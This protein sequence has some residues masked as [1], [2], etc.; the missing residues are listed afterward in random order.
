MTQL[1]L[2]V[3]GE[4]LVLP[5]CKGFEVKKEPG[6]I[7]VEMITRRTVLEQRGDIW[8]VSYQYGFFDDETKSRVL[9]ACEKGREKPIYCGFLPPNSAGALLY[10][11]F[12]V[13]SL[14][15]PKFMWSRSVKTE[16]GTYYPTPLWADFSIELREVRPSA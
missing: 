7:S 15:Y 12:Y 2:D 8:V 4:T 13:S 1:I 14:V 3:G 5:E 6:V 16:D 9:S 10:R 11:N